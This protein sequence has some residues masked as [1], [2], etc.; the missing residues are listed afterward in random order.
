MLFRLF[1]GHRAWIPPD[2]NSWIHAWLVS[3]DSEGPDQPTQ[4]CILILACTVSLCLK[5][6]FQRQVKLIALL[7]IPLSVY[8]IGSVIKWY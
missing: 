2:K 5:V 6:L 8:Y 1:S 3:T 7:L 4:M